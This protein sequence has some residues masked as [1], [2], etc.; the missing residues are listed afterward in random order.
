[1][2][3]APQSPNRQCPLCGAPVVAGV[4][5]CRSCGEWVQCPHCGNARQ[6]AGPMCQWCGQAFAGPTGVPVSD[7][8]PAPPA[9]AT[10]IPAAAYMNRR[11]S[12]AFAIVTLVLLFFVFPVGL[13]LTIIGL[14]TGPRR[15]CFLAMFLMVVGL[16]VLS[17]LLALGAILLDPELWEE[18]QNAARTAVPGG[19][20]VRC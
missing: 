16:F 17:V 15:G 9:P 13:L 7:P 4:V 14:F 1:M 11:G 8:R 5:K 20:D 12:P 10:A 19:A 3:S 6:A 18:L 2:T